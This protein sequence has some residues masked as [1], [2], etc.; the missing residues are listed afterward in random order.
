MFLSNL[1]WVCVREPGSCP[2][3]GYLNWCWTARF[4]K[5]GSRAAAALRTREVSKTYQ[6][7]HTCNRTD[8]HSEV[9]H[10][11]VR[12][13][14]MPLM[15]IN[16]LGVGRVNKSK[17][18]SLCSDHGPLFITEMKNTPLGGAS[19]GKKRQWSAT[20]NA[21]APVHLAFCCCILWKLSHCWWWRL[22]Y[23]HGHLDRID[24]PSSLSDVNEAEMLVFFCNN[25]T[26]GTL[27][28]GQTDRLLGND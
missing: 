16:F 8:Q 13:L 21:T 19:G 7:C 5:Q 4:T 1:R 12:F 23:Y 25:T 14:Q 28:T 24:G 3:T 27:L 9:I 15:K 17:Q 6:G 10:P 20:Y 22:R 18:H 11:A 2:S 26:N